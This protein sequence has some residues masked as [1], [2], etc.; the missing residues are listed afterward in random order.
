[1]KT[2]RK[3]LLIS[4]AVMLIAAQ[5]IAAC[6][7][8][9]VG[10]KA[11]VD[12]STMTSHT[13]DSTGD[14][15]RL[16][17]IPSIPAGSVQ[18]IVLDGRAGADFGKYPEVVDYGLRGMKLGEFK[19]EKATNQYVH[20]MYS[21]L[22][23]KGLA[24]GESTCSRDRRS[25]QGQKLNTAFGATE[26][27]LDCYMLQD[28]A[29]ETCSTAREAVDFMGKMIEEYGWNG[30]CECINICDG[31]EAWVLEAYGGPVWVAI[32]VPD[33][34][35]FV[36]ANRAR[37]NVLIENDPNNYRYYKD[38]KNYALQY[39]LW[40][41]KSA[42]QPNQIFAPYSSI[43]CSLREWRVMNILDPSLNLK[44]PVDSSDIK[45][46]KDNGAALDYPLFVTPKEKISVQTVKDICSD[47]YQG[48]EYDVSKTVIS[49]PF[50]NPLNTNYVYR[51]IN[52]P[53]ATYVQISNIRPDLPDEIKCL[54]WVGFGSALTNYLTPIWG[55]QKSF[56]AIFNSR[57]RT[58]RYGTDSAWWVTLG[59]QQEAQVNYDSAIQDIRAVRDAKQEALYAQTA[60]VQ[61]VAASMVNSGMESAAINYITNYANNVANDWNE[62]YIELDNLLRS[63]YMLGNVN[64]RK[65]ALG[66]WYNDI[67]LENVV[68]NLRPSK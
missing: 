61:D 23:D 20:A 2:T 63:K 11:T 34:Q 41:G 10:N 32:R 65:Q 4:L 3:V 9:A 45:N 33:N 30:A 49:G 48:T 53:Q 36:A 51:P 54:A 22:N 18:D 39:D 1:M 66:D 12:G 64:M 27:I 60:L 28:L 43:L 35:V 56:P 19:I 38:I 29:L 59:V 16:W 24:M 44:S 31:N 46:L 52:V 67:V 15:I 47:Y 55:S 42:F 7:I 57:T 40:D 6:T 13:C 25:E 14:D 26:G 21:F 58:D 8:L 50:G 62:T 68:D 17:L 37:I 5:T